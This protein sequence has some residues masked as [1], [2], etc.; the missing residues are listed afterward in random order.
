MEARELD[1]GGLLEV[2]DGEAELAV[3]RAEQVVPALERLDGGLAER[4]GGGGGWRE[5]VCAAEADGEREES[6]ERVG[7]E[8]AEELGAHEELVG[9][10][11]GEEPHLRR[12]GRGD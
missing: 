9:D 6:V 8:G 1:A 3:V 4:R 12:K 7:E 11:E 2:L 10:G 5:R